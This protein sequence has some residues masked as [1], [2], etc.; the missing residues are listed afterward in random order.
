MASLP[1]NLTMICPRCGQEMKLI[2]VV[3]EA[4]LVPEKHVFVCPSCGEAEIKRVRQ[5]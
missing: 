1:N 3:P 2:R 4:A 5:T